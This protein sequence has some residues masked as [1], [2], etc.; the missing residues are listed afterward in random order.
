MTSFNWFISGNHRVLETI[1]QDWQDM[2]A[3]FTASIRERV[4]HVETMP[5]SQQFFCPY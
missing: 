4:Q 2:T 1:A 3:S 5:R